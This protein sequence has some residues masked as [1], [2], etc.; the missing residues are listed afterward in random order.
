MKFWSVV[1]TISTFSDDE[2]REFEIEA[3]DLHDAW[4]Q[5]HR[6]ILEGREQIVSVTRDQPDERHLAEEKDFLVNELGY[7]EGTEL[8][9]ENGEWVCLN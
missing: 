1:K 2:E 7:E 8:Y 5:A 9:L 4:D 3:V 6:R